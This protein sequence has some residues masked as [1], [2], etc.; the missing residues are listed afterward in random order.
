MNNFFVAKWR[1]ETYRLINILLS[2]YRTLQ[3]LSI[4]NK[5]KLIS[6]IYK[7]KTRLRQK[8]REIF[9]YVI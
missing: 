9:V 5:D 1:I 2:I 3:E 4:Y 7:M 6:D 8:P